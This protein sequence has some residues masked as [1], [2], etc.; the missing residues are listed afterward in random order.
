MSTTS[1]VRD[2]LVRHS[3]QEPRCGP[4]GNSR[5]AEGDDLCRLEEAEAITF[6]VS[7]VDEFRRRASQANNQPAKTII[8]TGRAPGVNKMRKASIAPKARSP[9]TLSPSERSRRLDREEA[10]PA[11][12]NVRAFPDTRDLTDTG[13]AGGQGSPILPAPA[14]NDDTRGED[15]PREMAWTDPKGSGP[16]L[17]IEERPGPQW[18]RSP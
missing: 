15:R 9:R 7:P 13:P 12:S 2:A 5:Q 8:S 4:W 14:T 16:L 17:D 6:S 3:L 18:V 10:S 11:K 1:A